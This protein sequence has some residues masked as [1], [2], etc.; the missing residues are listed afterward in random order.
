MVELL[1][2]AGVE[3]KLT[4][5]VGLIKEKGVY[6]TTGT[7]QFARVGECGDDVQVGFWLMLGEIP[8]DCA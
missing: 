5:G 7:I 3:G 2:G 8:E 1:V 6:L 4:N